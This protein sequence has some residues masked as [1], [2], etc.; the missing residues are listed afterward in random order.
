MKRISLKA[1]NIV[2]SWA[3]KSRNARNIVPEIAY[4]TFPTRQIG[5]FDAREW[6]SVMII[7]A[8]SEIALERGDPSLF[9]EWHLADIG[10]A[11]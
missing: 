7:M 2:W 10:R 11:L 5:D 9:N 6:H 1:I 8:I 4:G 3:I